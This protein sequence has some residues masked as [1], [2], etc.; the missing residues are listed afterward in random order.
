VL[1][2]T[3]D[4]TSPSIG[5]LVTVVLAALGAAVG[6]VARDRIVHRFRSRAD[7]ADLGVLTANLAACAVVGLSA[8]AAKDATAAQALVVLGF[9]GGLSTW[10][11]L[12]IEVAGAMRARQWSM[13]LL[14][15]PG[16]FALALGV[17]LAARAAAEAVR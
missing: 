14:H 11:S 2:A 4:A 9:A 10:S 3:D 15:V 12:A 16:A 17:Y 8:S 6:S 13:V 7:R 5:L 1:L